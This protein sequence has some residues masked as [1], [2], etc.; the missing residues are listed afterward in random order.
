MGSTCRTNPSCPIQYRSP[1]QSVTAPLLDLGVC[2]VRGDKLCHEWWVQKLKISTRS[3]ATWQTS[4]PSIVGWW[5]QLGRLPVGPPHM[6][7]GGTRVYDL[8]SEP[9]SL[10]MESVNPEDPTLLPTPNLIG[11]RFFF[12]PFNLYAQHRCDCACVFENS[13]RFGTTQLNGSVIQ[14]FYWKNL[15]WLPRVSK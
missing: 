11:I 12:S 13:A 15:C 8:T 1:F 9:K 2:C 5:D 7:I 6:T 10:A 14:Y 4:D 3:H